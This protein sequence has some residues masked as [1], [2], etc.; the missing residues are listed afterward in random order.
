MATLRLCFMIHV[1][2]TQ[3]WDEDIAVDIGKLATAAGQY[4][5][6]VSL[7]IGRKFVDDQQP[8]DPYDPSVPTSLSIVL[9]KG[10]NFWAHTHDSSG[11]YLRSTHACVVSAFVNENAEAGTNTGTPAGRS[12]GWESD[13]SADWVS[14]TQG[15]GLR[16][17]NSAVMGTHGNVPVTLRPYGFSADEIDKLYPKGQAPGPLTSEIATMRCRP[18]FVEVSSYWFDMADKNTRQSPTYDNL[19][20]IIMIPA[21]GKLDLPGLALG[22][23]ADE[24]SS[25]VLTVEDMN[26]ALTQ[27]WTTYQLMD[28]YQPNITN[29]WYTHIPEREIDDDSATT[30]GAFVNSINNL[31]SPAANREWK[32]MNEIASIFVDNS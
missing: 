1:E 8:V 7:Q 27:V 4:G 21:P 28:S 24:G 11:H 29:A 32:N 15:E 3:D 2:S 13:G 10:G 9:E 22:R 16:L 30:L 26:A 18:F 5:G 6:K 23:T 19:G 20:S 25:G 14:V 31:I 12:G 17:M